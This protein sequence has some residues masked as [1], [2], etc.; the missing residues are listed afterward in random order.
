MT[1]AVNGGGGGGGG[2]GSG[3]LNNTIPLLIIFSH[4]RHPTRVSKICNIPE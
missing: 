4:W 1:A 2:G 3:H